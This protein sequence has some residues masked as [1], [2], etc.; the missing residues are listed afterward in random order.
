MMEIILIIICVVL[1]MLPPRYDPA[2]RLK[3]FTKR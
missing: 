2:I 3:E 1:V